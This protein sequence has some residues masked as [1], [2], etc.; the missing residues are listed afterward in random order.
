MDDADQPGSPDQG[1]RARRRHLDRLHGEHKRQHETLRAL[2]QSTAAHGGTTA[3]RAGRAE[4][5]A[6]L[7]EEGQRLHEEDRRLRAERDRG[8]YDQAAHAHW[9]AALAAH[10]EELRRFRGEGEGEGEGAAPTA[11]R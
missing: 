4:E 9:Y 10:R 3:D 6:R 5:L 8:R 1:T 11:I 7:H 2:S